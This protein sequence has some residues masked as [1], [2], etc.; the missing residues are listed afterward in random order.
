MFKI[1]KYSAIISLILLSMAQISFA[2]PAECPECFTPFTWVDSVANNN[3]FNTGSAQNYSF[4]YDI[5]GS[6]NAL[7]VLTDLSNP[8]DPTSD[9]INSADLLL[10][11]SW[12]GAATKNLNI[13]LDAGSQAELP[14]T[15]TSLSNPHDITLN[16]SVI[17][18]LNTDGTLVMD[19]HDVT[20]VYTLTN[21]V[22][23]AYGCDKTT[24]D[25][26]EDDGGGG[27]GNPVPEPSTFLLLGGG[28]V[29]VGLVRK[30]LKR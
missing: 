2:T 8:F 10:T 11:F 9:F 22:L 21:S 16:G 18:Q 23:T 6:G 28:L 30:G 26:G 25:G 27:G 3:T 20:G 4:T 5:T 12:S 7:N 17:A 1:L 24:D 14:F 13:T 19:L 29:G 15:I